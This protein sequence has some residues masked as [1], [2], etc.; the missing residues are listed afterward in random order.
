MDGEAWAQSQ[1]YI[2]VSQ[3]EIGIDQEDL[4]THPGKGHSQVDDNIRL[5]YAT[6]ARSHRNDPQVTEYVLDPR[7]GPAWVKSSIFSKPHWFIPRY[8]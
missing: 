1:K 5:A 8:L 4:L 7:E 6:F 2:Q 3:T